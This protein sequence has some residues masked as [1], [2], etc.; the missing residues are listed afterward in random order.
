MKT[1]KIKDLTLTRNQTLSNKVKEVTTFLSTHYDIKIN[2]FDPNPNKA[3]II[4]K[5]REYKNGISWEEISLHLL[6]ESISVSDTVLKKILRSSNYMKTFDPI[7]EYF[8][9]IEGTWKGVSHI[10]LLAAHIKVREYPGFKRDYFTIRM[11]RYLK[12]WFVATVA[13]ALGL[14]PNDVALG[15]VHEDDGIGKTFLFDFITPEPLKLF[16]CNSKEDPRK[17]DV[18]EAFATNF[19][20]CFDELVGVNKRTTQPIKSTMSKSNVSVTLPRELFQKQ[21]QRISSACF[22]SNQAPEKGG[23]ITPAMGYRR[24]LVIELKYIK[25]EYSE[26]CDINQIWAEALTLI[27]QDYDYKWGE[28]DFN[29][30]KKVNIRYNIETPSMKYLR[31][32]FTIPQNGE[33]KWLQPQEILQLLISNRC[34]KGDDRGKVNIQEIG[35]ALKQ[36]GFPR[37]K[38]YRSPNEKV[39]CYNV[40]SLS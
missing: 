2:K 23:F 14:H 20:I 26:K 8:D 15:L 22:T 38:K 16:F 3:I 33:G 31:M 13:C 11:A 40:T 17:F 7:Q 27:K 37:E 1:E 36:L 10:D 12:K 21:M 24:W 9:S 18:E 5:T 30:F 4:P 6:E 19:L 39:Y 32:Y 25:K 28:T 34:I 35:R 29:E